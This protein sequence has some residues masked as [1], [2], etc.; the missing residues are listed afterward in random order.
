MLVSEKRLAQ[1]LG[2]HY[3]TLARWRAEGKAPRHIMVG[4]QIRYR[5]EDVNVWIKEVG[6][7]KKR[8]VP[9]VKTVPPSVKMVGA[10]N[11]RGAA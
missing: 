9:S 4:C 1:V 2:I 7:H 8:G 10:K 3:K 5:Q 11:F 6:Q